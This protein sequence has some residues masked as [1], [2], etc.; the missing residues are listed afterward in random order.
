MPAL[1]LTENNMIYRQR[2][3]N[4]LSETNI[5]WLSTLLSSECFV[6]ANYM[7]ST[8]QSEN[9]GKLLYKYKV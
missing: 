8:K 2:I 3:C 6:G 4:L 7:M 5:T 9:S 1:E